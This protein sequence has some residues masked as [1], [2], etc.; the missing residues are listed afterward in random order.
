MRS[1]LLAATALAA[2]GS[3]PFAALAQDKAGPIRIGLGGEFYGAFSLASQSTGVGPDGI[4]GT[5]DDAP[6]QNRRNNGFL[7]VAKIYFQGQTDLDNG[8][9]VGV[10]IKLNAEDCLDQIDTAFIWFDGGYG[11]FEY[12][13]TSGAGDAMFI[14]APDPVS[15]MGLNSPDLF[16]VNWA[17]PAGTGN[18]A[19]VPVTKVD[20]STLERLNY[21]T[22]RILGIQLGLSYAPVECVAGNTGTLP[23]GG[24][25]NGMPADN[26]PRGYDL[27]QGAATWLG[28]IGPVKLGLYGSYMRARTGDGVVPVSGVPGTGANRQWGV[29]GQIAY[30]GFSLGGGYRRSIDDAIFFR[31]TPDLNASDWNL[32]LTYTEGNWHGGVQYAG[33]RTTLA[34]REDS[35]D[36]ASV[37]ASYLIGPGIDLFAAVQYYDWRTDSPLPATRSAAT[38]EA[39]S[40][41]LGTSIDF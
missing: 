5:A 33:K 20:T 29:G 8:L 18:L 41:S 7:R 19:A 17:N 36:G 24:T 4:A 16:V 30:A 14:G 15:H 22:P 2:V 38:N 31:Y 32:G 37:G 3:I 1:T 10:L 28:A 25:Y 21:F 27:L 40:A 13:A 12:G 11:R 9:R 39:W 35:F 26:L 23:C 34:G 6:G